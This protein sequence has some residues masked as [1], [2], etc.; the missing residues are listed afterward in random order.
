MK[1]EQVKIT[2]M[3]RSVLSIVRTIL[4]WHWRVAVYAMLAGLLLF[5]ALVLTLRYWLLPDIAEYR[6]DIA[7]S[8][9]RAAGQRVTIGKIDAGWEGLRPHLVLQDVRVYDQ[10]SRPVL[11]L[12]QIENTL[13]WWSLFVGEA[14]F[15]SLIIEHPN[16]VVR[17][18]ANGLIFVGGIAVNQAETS[19]GF[20]DWMLKQNHILVRDAVVLW[21]DN[22]R[23]APPLVL[24]NVGLNL[25]NHGARHLFGVRATPASELAAPLDLR[26]D[27]SGESLS[28]LNDWH[29]TLYARL[30]Y[31]DLAGW[32]KWLSYPVEMRQGTGAVQM[33]VGF[34]K[35][36][37]NEL[38]GD[39]H[40]SG[41]KVRLAP[42]VP[43]LD[44]KAL[45]GRLSW[46][47]SKNGY[48][49]VAKKLQLVT[50]DGINVGPSNF[51]GRFK[52]AFGKS[53]AAGEADAD[54]LSMEP[55]LKLTGYLPLPETVRQKMIEI[56]P[57][58]AFA[59]LSAKWVGDWQ[60][61]KKYSVKGRFVNFGI[62]PYRMLPGLSGVSGNLDANETGG[63]LSLDSRKASVEMKKVFRDAIPFDSLI[64]QA[65]WKIRQGNLNVKLTN[66]SFAN[67][68]LAGNAYGSFQTE[69]GT[70]GRIDLTGS[71]TRGDARFVGR[72]IP[73]VVGED[74]RDW[75]DKA[76]LGGKSTDARLRL[77][78]NLADF[79]FADDKKGIFQVKAKVTGG[80]LDYVP[81]WPKIDSITA[82]LL[83]QGDRMEVNASKASINGVALR[84]VR[85]QIPDLLAPDEMLLIDGEAQG[86]TGNF[87]QY[88]N[89]SPVAD[90]VGGVTHGMQAS[91]NGTLALKL[92]IPLRHSK[93]SKISGDFLPNDNRI[94]FGKSLPVLEKV[95]GKFEFTE[96]A[97]RAQ[98]MTAQILGGPVAISAE[99][100]Q[101][102]SIRITAMGK[103]T[104]VGLRKSVTSPWA[105]YINGT[106]DWHAL[107]T[108][109]NQLVDVT[110][111][112]SMLGLASDLPAPFAKNAAAA[113][114][115]HFERK[116]GGPQQD[117]ISLSYGK[118]F[119]AKLLRRTEGDKTRIDRGALS[120]GGAEAK[121]AESGVW[122]TGTLPY[123]NMDQWRSV[124]SQSPAQEGDEPLLKLSGVNLAINTLETFNRRFGDFH[125]N[126]WDTGDSWQATLNSR[127]MNGD[128]NW[129][130]KGRGRIVAHLKNL[131]VPEEIP[132]TPDA[133]MAAASTKELPALDIVADSLE[134]RH[135]KLGKLEVLAV[136]Q[137]NDWKIEK[138]KL[139]NPD[140]VLQMDGLWQAWLLRP[141]TSANL[142]LDVKDIGKFLARF[143]YP[144]AVKRG[145]AKLEGKLAWMGS[146]SEMDYPTLTGQFT[147]AAS[148]GQ[149]LKIEPG[150]GK[151]LGILSLQSLPRRITLDFRDIFSEGFAFNA[152]SGS[153][154]ID[155]GVLHS[156]DFIIEGPAAVVSMAGET[157]IAQETQK[158][159]VRVVPVLGEGVSI[160]G[161]FLGGPVVGL[162]SLLIQKILKD[163][164]GQ[165]IAYEYGITGTWDDPKVTKINRTSG[166]PATE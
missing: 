149:F 62:N 56:N 159:R 58:G 6:E 27:I 131:T 29:G 112:S 41:V 14:R 46:K 109:R 28:D 102:H 73:L 88:I 60:E 153:M 95:N 124:V 84:K 155:R 4:H 115:L 145:S 65:S 50:E 140:M 108:M 110:V 81:G 55:L 23:Q 147:L 143:G 54:S 123:L 77:K 9:S 92:E 35:K 154:T 37:I 144:D 164:F 57:R 113:L 165:L 162:T 91:G 5:S 67:A 12:S 78:G 19:S 166:S 99:P 156:D 130:S 2:N 47:E 157:D 82:D 93:D 38:T 136:Q 8:I 132:V 1:L 70:P 20:A 142:K 75:L 146:P 121:P 40:L 79:P 51:K 3:E 119:A 129:N 10:Q 48:E 36:K 89:L 61:P 11:H 34:D 122:V 158:L 103:L 152:I 17:R 125:L 151:L 42:E 45:S 64:A 44:L 138:L 104:A 96:S 59:D 53:A 150:I 71:L 101:D 18:E 105:K 31:A 85:A 63:T 116:S 25:E 114:P 106:A 49:L 135:R 111:D 16:L 148:N 94:M 120:F 30:D 22:L 32:R 24:S 69:K 117:V 128:I 90:M 68:H 21:Q 74:A 87:I 161:A 100:Q 107:I 137:G 33:W 83:F 80:A 86:P 163:P 141:Q 126:A 160:A 133:K 118:I 72:Y 13:S 66:V 39:L 52:S 139:A 134:V 76:F 43:E 26:G 97:I 127:E 7:A 98:K 15:S